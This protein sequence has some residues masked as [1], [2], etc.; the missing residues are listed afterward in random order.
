MCKNGLN[1]EKNAY[2]IF[3]F[4]LNSLIT[5]KFT[6]MINRNLSFSKAKFLHVNFF[7]T[8]L[9]TISLQQSFVTHQAHTFLNNSVYE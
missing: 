2:I 9:D 7:M 3:M 4:Y 6:L 8:L 1:E 5:G